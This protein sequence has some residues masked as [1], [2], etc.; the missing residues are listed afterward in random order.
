MD[1]SEYIKDV[2]RQITRFKSAKFILKYLDEEL[3]YIESKLK[4]LRDIRE[5]AGKTGTTRGKKRESLETTKIKATQILKKHALRAIEDT[6][7]FDIAIFG[8]RLMAAVD[9]PRTIKLNIVDNTLLVEIDLNQTAGPLQDY[10]NA[11]TKTREELQ[12]GPN[13][14]NGT[15]SPELA[16]H[17]WKEKYYG[18]AREGKMIP[19]RK[20]KENSKRKRQ[21]SDRTEYYRVSYWATIYARIANFST[22]APFWQIIN[23]GTTPLDSDW[24]GTAYPNI[25]PTRFVE[26]AIAEIK[27]NFKQEPTGVVE[28]FEKIDAIISELEAK[29]E[30]IIDRIQTYAERDITK[31]VDEKLQQRLK[32]K[33]PLA[34]PK[35][36]ERFIED[37]LA[38]REFGE[39]QELGRAGTRVRVRTKNFYL[40]LLGSS[41]KINVSRETR[42]FINLLLDK[43]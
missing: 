28:D 4:T 3:K 9:D 10:A 31:L 25:S 30:Y 12:I 33:F 35:R 36:I 2:N 17:M 29:R 37:A 39:K 6:K 27:R 1:Y 16:S 13:K 42:R 38:G 5:S 19:V 41:G 7:E 20:Q 15:M 14:K 18:S 11:I 24:G 43:K 8:N 34:D 21:A 26:K 23:D 32:D 40:D 22:L